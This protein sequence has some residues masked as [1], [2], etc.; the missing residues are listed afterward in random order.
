MS[1]GELAT[2]AIAAMT[3]LAVVGLVAAAVRWYESYRRKLSGLFPDPRH[4][5]SSDRV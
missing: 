1:P 2:L 4:K 3:G 5:A